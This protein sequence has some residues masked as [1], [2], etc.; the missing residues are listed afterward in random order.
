[1]KDMSI[2]IAIDGPAGAGKST[3]AREFAN[4]LH[5]IYVDTGAMYRGMAYYFLKNKLDV[6]NQNIICSECTNINLAI[7]YENGF[8][9][10]ICNDED[11][12]NFIRTEAVGNAASIVSSYPCVREHLLDMQKKLAENNNV[13][14]DGR[15]IGT[16]VLPNAQLKIYFT[17]S[18]DCRAK[19]R[20]DELI[21]K[22]SQADY[23][24]I[25]AEIKDRDYRDMNR[26]TAPLKQAE[27][28]ILLDSSNLSIHEVLEQLLNLYKEVIT[29]N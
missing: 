12:T 18:V 13:I 17:A 14:M 16:C 20:Y 6:T 29:C 2:N 8:Q 9:H 10:V 15:D 22:N 21:T 27:D 4:R 3:I 26:E 19:R 11:I 1:M 23:D 5:F 25:F 28:A 7:N 24:K